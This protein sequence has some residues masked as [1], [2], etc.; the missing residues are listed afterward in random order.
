MK[1]SKKLSGLL[2]LGL[3]AS[4]ATLA[5]GATSA[6]AATGAYTL[7][8]SPQ[9]QAGTSSYGGKPTIDLTAVPSGTG[10]VIK[11]AI[12]A[13][14]T[15]TSFAGFNAGAYRLDAYVRIDDG[16]QL[17]LTGTDPSLNPA[18]P[19]STASFPTG[20]TATATVS[21]LAQGPH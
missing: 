12:T 15:T 3:V 21:D 7:T 9:N 16:P 11:A 4:S 1:L 10:V 18:V 8:G 2:A 13:G 5:V 17:Q 14:P 19:V 6:Q 20:T